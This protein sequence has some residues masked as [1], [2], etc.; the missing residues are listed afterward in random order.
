M[1]YSL[2]DP[3]EYEK[4]VQSHKL[5]QT[6]A[7]TKNIFKHPNVD[8][9]EKLDNQM[10]AIL[11]NQNLSDFEKNQQFGT[12]LESF[13]KNF[14]Q[15]IKTPKADA[16]FGKQTV[17]KEAVIPS[18]NHSK[19]LTKEIANI[20]ESYQQRAR[21]LVEFLQ[22][23]KSFSW[24]EN[25][26][27]KYK[28]N[29]IDDSDVSKLLNDAVRNKKISSS[30]SVFQDFMS[31]LKNEGY[32]VHRLSSLKEK[33]SKIS[34]RTPKKV[35]GRSVIS[36]KRKKTSFIPKALSSSSKKEILKSW[37]SS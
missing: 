9:A 32:P 17:E 29:V 14:Q 28:G 12:K 6:K 27:L 19:P 11:S 2:V 4:L 10:S 15:A 37:I 30:L 23:N 8:K 26:Q 36:T 3:I 35:P 22:S 25:G 24:N 18:E 33:K 31:A 7:E 20:P 5:M 1:K 21:R 34:K 13:I 16:F